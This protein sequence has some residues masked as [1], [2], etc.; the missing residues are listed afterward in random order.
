MQ[1]NLT[2]AILSCLTFLSCS[3]N[4]P[5]YPTTYT[6]EGFMEYSKKFN[7][8][9]KNLENQYF[10]EYIKN[11][12]EYEFVNTNAG[13]KMSKTEMTDKL[14]QDKDTVSYIYNVKDLQDSIIY[15]A[16]TIGKK[17][18]V[19]GQTNTIIG[20]EYALKRMKPGEKS[21]LLL[22]SSLAYGTNGDGKNI[23]IN[24]PLIIEIE[25]LENKNR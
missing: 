11:H 14:T 5:Q 3:K 7:K 17:T 12:P 18:E 15:D 6:G 1:K 16:K 20:I 13:F 10:E 9:L 2:I 4:P 22:P 24:Q 23:G 25:L 21:I 19:M 8:D